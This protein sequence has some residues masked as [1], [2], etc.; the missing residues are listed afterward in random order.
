MKF[1]PWCLSFILGSS[2]ADL[3]Q[4][5]DFQEPVSW[6]KLNENISPAGAARGTVIAARSRSAPDYYYHW[7]RDAGLVM[8]V[9]RKR[10]ESSKDATEKAKLVAAFDDF[11][12]LSVKQQSQNS[13]S[14]PAW[15]MGVAE[16]KYF[17]DGRPFD[18]G[19]GRPQTDG[20]A[21]RATT[22]IRM[23]QAMARNGDSSRSR[24]WYDGRFPSYSVI[25][26][27]LEF[28]ASC[29]D[30]SG[31]N[32]KEAPSFDLWEEVLGGHFYTRMVQRKALL[33]GAEFAR[34]L[35]DRGAA[36]HYARK[37]AK[38]E[39]TLQ[40]FWSE[41]NGLIEVTRGQVRGLDY[42]DSQMDSAIV[43]AALHGSLED[44]V[45]SPWDSRVLLTLSA[46]S[47]TFEGLYPINRTQFDKKGAPLAPAIGRYPEDKYNGLDSKTEANP[48][49]LT[50]SAFAEALYITAARWSEKGEIA[51]DDNL[52]SFLKGLDSELPSQAGQT[53]RSNSAEFAQVLE[54]VVA[55]GDA[56]LNRVRSRA[57]ARGQL[58]EQFNRYSGKL[59]GASELTWSHAAL[60]TA[61]QAR[62][63]VAALRKTAAGSR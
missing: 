25:K 45:F 15:G 55:R 4:W 42:K 21:I 43:L 36:D 14:G 5:L 6:Q 52:V 47:D 17:V 63:K 37:A 32:L 1:I 62:D 44:G 16:P 2:G 28:V 38:I 18:G 39:A 9:L 33:V 29:W 40:E 3:T 51:V 31:P 8:D 50:T 56:Y 35:G 41:E 24:S 34:S 53:L 13:L 57:G 19:W 10:Y 20:P 61:K 26:A 54:A 49:F 46:L 30:D 23:A 58:S 59:R 12:Q 7:T 48:W 27:D 11:V 22:L 60:L